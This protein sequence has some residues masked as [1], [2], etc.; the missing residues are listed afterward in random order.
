MIKNELSDEELMKLYQ[1]DD[2]LAFE[3]LYRRYKKR[4]YT[5]VNSKVFDKNL[6]DEVFQSIFL[7][8][9]KSRHLYRDEFL[10]AQWIYT[11]SKNIIIDSLRKN[12]NIQ[13]DDKAFTNM[14][15][16]VDSQM[17]QIDLN[18][19]TDKEKT[20]IHLRYDGEKE[21]EEIAKILQTN[22]TNVR[23]IISR[24]ISKLKKKIS[25]EVV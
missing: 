12:K 7:K 2:V 11:V 16:S 23:K 18:I 4:I 10:F 5:Y 21:F 8:L 20:A 22:Q 1:Q 25:S 14:G 17:D 9:H 13:S 15:E 19:L 6:V 24:A 3:E